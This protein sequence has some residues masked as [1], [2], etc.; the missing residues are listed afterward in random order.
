MIRLFWSPRKWVNFNSLK[1]PTR[2]PRIV[3]GNIPVF[4]LSFILLA[5]CK[6]ES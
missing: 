6:M 2:A 4:G 5:G 1:Q 3:V